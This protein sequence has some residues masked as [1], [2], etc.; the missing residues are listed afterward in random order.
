MF[1]YYSSLN[2]SMDSFGSSLDS[3]KM[4]THTEGSLSAKVSNGDSSDTKPYRPVLNRATYWDKRVKE[5]LIS[6]S[7]V[8]EKFPT[9]NG[10]ST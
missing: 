10:P 9:L 5:G 8:Q 2:E 7:T 3:G 6:D 4:S 1:S